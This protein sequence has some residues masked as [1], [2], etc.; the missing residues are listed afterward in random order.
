M[1]LFFECAACGSEYS[2]EFQTPFEYC[3]HMLR[4]SNASNPT[5]PGLFDS[6][7]VQV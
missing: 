6:K 2:K 5:E 4:R 3:C 7:S 1:M